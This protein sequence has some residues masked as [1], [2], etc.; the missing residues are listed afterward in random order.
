MTIKLR[1]HQIAQ[2]GAT[3]GQT[4]LWDAT[5]QEWKPATLSTTA[6]LYDA[7]GDILIATAADTPARVPVGA[8]AKVLTADSAAST[9]VAWHGNVAVL[10][11]NGATTPPA[12][13]PIGAIVFEKGP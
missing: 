11:E 12:G 8:N 3:N 10:I 5:A 7:K 4:L 1:P 6:T 2:E 13:T 9:G